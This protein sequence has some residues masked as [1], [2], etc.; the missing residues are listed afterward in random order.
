[1]WLQALPAQEWGEARCS[2]RKA[3]VKSGSAIKL[4]ES[5]AEDCKAGGQAVKFWL[6]T[7]EK[8]IRITGQGE[9]REIGDLKD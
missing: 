3:G 7:M 8:R 5:E 2:I 6:F 4:Q 1:M 9:K